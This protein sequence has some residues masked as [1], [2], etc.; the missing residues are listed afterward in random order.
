M[1][2]PRELLLGA[3]MALAGGASGWVRAGL[4]ALGVG[5]G[6][7]LLLVAISVP[8]AMA[9][10]DAREAARE[11][12][13]VS[14]SA[15]GPSDTTILVG[16]ADTRFHGQSIRGRLLRPDGTRP[17]VPPGLAAIP[18]PGEMVVSPA[19]A[20]LLAS[21]D[22]GLLRE[23]LD[24]LLVATISDEG[25]SGPNEL[26]FYLG[27]DD[28]D[29]TGLFV[30]RRVAFGEEPRP[31]VTDPVASIIV[32]VVV[33]VLLLPVGLFVA[34]ATR[35]GVE[36]R[37]RRLAGVRL[38]GAD[39]RM[40]RR[41]AS[42][43]ALAG[44]VLGLLVGGALFLALRS[45]VDR[46]HLLGFSAF[47]GDIR[48]DPLLTAGLAV[49]V[50]VAAVAF[51]LLSLRRVVI[52]PMGVMRRAGDVR[53]R[54]WWRA[55]LPAVGTAL[56]VP[57]GGSVREGD[58]VGAV[59]LTAGMILVLVG[60]AALLPWAVAAAVRRLRGGPIAWQL[61]VRRLQLDSSTSARAVMGIAVAVAGAI[62]LQTMFAA[63]SGS[64]LRSTGMDPSRADV[65]AYLKLRG[66]WDDV[67]ALQARLLAAPGVRDVHSRLWLSVTVRSPEW[68]RPMASSLIVGECPAL[69][70]LAELDSCSE[71]DVF[72][73]EPGGVDPFDSVVPQ[74]GSTVLLDALPGDP[75]AKPSGE[76]TV[77][78]DARTVTARS[79]PVGGQVSGA[80][81]TPSAVP[82]EAL[83]AVVRELSSYMD[84]DGS[85]PEVLEQVRNVVWRID[86]AASVEPVIA[87]TESD[88]FANL[89]RA[90]FAGAT[91]TL[92]L[93][94]VSLLITALEQLRE[95]R[96]VLASL[97]AV[98]TRRRTLMWSILWQTAVPVALGLLLAILAGTTVGA[99]LLR[100]VEQPLR[101]DWAGVGLV[102]GVG[103]G[104]VLAVTALTSPA[105][106][107]LMRAQG[108]RTE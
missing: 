54:L 43:E 22:A 6:V 21:P 7:A 92:L 69:R 103:A 35:F 33:V 46:V 29:E 37:D 31:D 80:L 67:R 86:P 11:D 106:F 44:S 68:P 2:Y 32:P 13:A 41:I 45:F 66:D 16:R 10:R 91:L 64:Y 12:S 20:R 47:P 40:G 60:V 23:R 76:W 49:A 75:T 38:L 65:A 97:V 59:Q 79:D 81:V 58:V 50:P 104:V 4:T 70:Q 108:L 90:L 74:P 18:R 48:P 42:G 9:A 1:R 53:R 25:L 14:P 5:V 72:L 84:I 98:G 83:A 30:T 56:L 19:L 62:A 3:R 55:L 52:E 100:I 51:T 28:L 17:P 94:G 93:I 61:A 77:P 89:R 78:P 63:V 96:R 34:A 26:A 8:S 39:V 95:R 88:V 105:L 15:L 71:G 99:L 82:P 102:T 27:V 24:Y 73:I 101:I 85:N 57:L 36:A 87:L 107:R